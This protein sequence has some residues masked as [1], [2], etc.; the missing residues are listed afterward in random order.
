VNDLLAE[1]VDFDDM[2]RALT[3]LGDALS[4]AFTEV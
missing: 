3:S 2:R 1:E 4:R